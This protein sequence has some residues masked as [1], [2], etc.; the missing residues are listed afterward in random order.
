MKVFLSYARAD[1][2]FALRLAADLQSAGVNLWVDQLDIPKGAV[3]DQEIENA[4]RTCT[5]V[6]AIL[7]PASVNS[8]NV[9]DEVSFAL[10]EKK[11]V[12][13]VLYRAC[14][15]P[16]RLRRFQYVDFTTEY[17]AGLSHVVEALSPDPE[18]KQTK[19]TAT[20]PLAMAAQKVQQPAPTVVIPTQP[21]VI[22]TRFRKLEG[23]T[24]KVNCVAFSPDGTILASGS[25]GLLSA[26][27]PF[28]SF[29]G[30][31]TV[32]LWR[33]S[34]G[35]LLR[36]LEGQKG[37]IGSVV[38]WSPKTGQVAKRDSRP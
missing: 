12:V 35:E 34:N 18:A 29:W 30:D 8:H 33:V 25:G 38:S 1:A 22:L 14:D 31:R 32:R 19:Q 36:T 37:S 24:S 3:W 28:G 9:M 27:A 21:Q 17:R 2:D 26:G 16:F 6:L 23:H 7:S 5:H 4:L 13:P 20:P 11:V 15:R 10:E